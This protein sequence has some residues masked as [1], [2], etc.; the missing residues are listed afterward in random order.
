MRT[1]IVEALLLSWFAHATA[2]DFKVWL[3]PKNCLP[4][5]L[6]QIHAGLNSSK[7]AEI[8]LHLPKHTSLHFVDK[9]RLPVEYAAGTYTQKS[10]WSLQAT[11]SGTI[12]LSD[13]VAVIS[14]AGKKTEHTIDP[15]TLEV[16]SYESIDD[17]KPLSLPQPDKAADTNSSW[18]IGLVLGLV[19]VTA[20]NILLKLRSQS[21]SRDTQA[22]ANPT[23]KDLI[24][25][26]ESRD[27]PTA[28]IE[29]ILNDSSV[30]LS[31]E[32]R[33]ALERAAYGKPQTDAASTLL[34]ALRKDSNS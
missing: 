11:T 17:S 16:A 29:A 34:T 24:E 5:D 13:I 15:L 8:D 14:Q 32:A 31:S 19:S 3:E 2:S 23:L 10:I 30:H 21:T 1:F 7:L 4:G 26:L 9:Q 28:V 27:V 25:A 12:E 22:S 20:I 6:V 18:M 33:T